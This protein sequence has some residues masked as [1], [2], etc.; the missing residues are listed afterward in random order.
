M[1]TMGDMTIGKENRIIALDLETENNPKPQKTLLPQRYID[2]LKKTDPLEIAIVATCVLS[3]IGILRGG[4]L[5]DSYIM[6][7]GLAGLTLSG[8]VASVNIFCKDPIGVMDK[9]ERSYTG[10]D[11][12]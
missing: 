3:E 12:H 6:L 5:N 2:R 8:L 7:G 9:I 10:K 4:Y 1:F 11:L